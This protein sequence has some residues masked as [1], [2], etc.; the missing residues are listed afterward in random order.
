MWSLKKWSRRLFSVGFS[1]SLCK[2]GPCTVL[3]WFR[4]FFW[5]AHLVWTWKICKIFATSYS[6][7]TCRSFFFGFASLG[8]LLPDL[9]LHFAYT[10]WHLGQIS[11]E[12]GSCSVKHPYRGCFEK[13][14]L[15]TYWNWWR[16]TSRRE[17]LGLLNLFLWLHFLFKTRANNFQLE[18]LLTKLLLLA[19]T[20]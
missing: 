16:L 6:F 20:E 8:T 10:G 7:F 13:A 15:G 19:G 5:P 2:V 4:V 18:F 14:A 12:K 9:C 11:W 3:T 17:V 1:Y